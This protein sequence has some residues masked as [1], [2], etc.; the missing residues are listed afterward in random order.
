M[1]PKHHTR[2]GSFL[3]SAGARVLRWLFQALGRTCRIDVV[4]GGEHLEELLREPRP[5]LLSFWHNRT[6]LGAHFIFNGLHRQGLE[7]TLLASH[8]RDGELVTRTFERW[9]IHTVRGSASRGGREAM[10]SLYRT[11]TKHGRSPIMIPDGPRGPIYE[12]KVGV[13]VLAQMS[14]APILPMGFAVRKYW[15]IKS[16][17]RMI[18][19]WP[20]SR[21]TLAVGAPQAIARDLPADELEAERRRLQ[22][23]LD[24]LTL[25]AEAAAG[26]VD[27]L[28]DR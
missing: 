6:F 2:F 11:I 13:A 1:R 12:F 7:I 24:G 17:D 3:V 27:S 10:R 14:R 25:E 16:W 19:P 9:G 18:V 20:F 21:I 28:R 8:S 5:V 22:A 26:A 15:R 23:L 4:S